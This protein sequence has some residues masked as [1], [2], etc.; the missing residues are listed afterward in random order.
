MPDHLLWRGSGWKCLWQLNIGW[1]RKMW[2]PPWVSMISYRG[3]YFSTGRRWCRCGQVGMLEQL[4]VTWGRGSGRGGILW[5]G[6][7][8]HMMRPG[9]KKSPQT[10]FFWVVNSIIAKVS[11]LRCEQRWGF[12]RKGWCRTGGKGF[13]RIL[14]IYITPVRAGKSMP[15]L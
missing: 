4:P 1:G 13:F 14:R 12:H 10:S 6:W 3:W 7:G 5:V 2:P 8:D 15:E 9:Q 11:V